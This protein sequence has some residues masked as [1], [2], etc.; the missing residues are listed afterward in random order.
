MVGAFDGFRAIELIVSVFALLIQAWQAVIVTTTAA[1][2]FWQIRRWHEESVTHKFEAFLVAE[3]YLYSD[4]FSRA[5]AEI[6]ELFQMDPAQFQGHF[7]SA[8]AFA[9]RQFNYVA[10]MVK[11]SYLDKTLLFRM[12]GLLLAYHY[13]RINLIGREYGTENTHDTFELYEDAW[14]LLEDAHRWYKA[15]EEAIG[16]KLEGVT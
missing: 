16:Q 11:H 12:E 2:L 5:M 3:R 1:A 6:E 7:K 4:S 8:V 14:Q 10:Q 15:N 13:E 9:L